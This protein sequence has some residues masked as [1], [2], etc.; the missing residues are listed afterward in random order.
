MGVIWE[1]NFRFV[2]GITA[3]S[4]GPLLASRILLKKNYLIAGRSGRM[5]ELAGDVL[6]PERANFLAR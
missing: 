5:E 4:S 6:L 3:S 1:G 2:R